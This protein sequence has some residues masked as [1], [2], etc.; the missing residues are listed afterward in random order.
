MV[1]EMKGFG[2]CVVLVSSLYP[3]T[4]P[5]RRM[6]AGRS[7]GLQRDALVDARDHDAS[8]VTRHRTAVLLSEVLGQRPCALIARRGHPHPQQ[9]PLE[10]VV[11]M[12]DKGGAGVDAAVVVQQIQ[13]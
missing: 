9:V 2:A 3:S 6:T 5:R 8:P 4:P 13:I 12:V 10:A 7:L 1:A 11:R